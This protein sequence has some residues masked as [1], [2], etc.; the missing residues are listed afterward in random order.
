LSGFLGQFPSVIPCWAF[1]NR[2]ALV[3]SP[4]L[5]RTE[6][7]PI[8]NAEKKTFTWTII[9][10]PACRFFIK[11]TAVCSSCPQ[12]VNHFF[13]PA[14]FHLLSPQIHLNFNLN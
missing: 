14:P 10:A 2:W 11:K 3:S 7:N 5:G 1:S 6:A 12:P 13:P 4:K 9:P 8:P